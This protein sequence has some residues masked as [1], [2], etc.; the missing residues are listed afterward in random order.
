MDPLV[1]NV[2]N[3]FIGYLNFGLKQWSTLRIKAGTSTYVLQN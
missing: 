2:L 1:L 3:V